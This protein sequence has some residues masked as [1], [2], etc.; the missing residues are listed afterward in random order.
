MSVSIKPLKGFS[1][2]INNESNTLSLLVKS[3][4]ELYEHLNESRNK[5]ISSLNSI[6]NYFKDSDIKFYHKVQIPLKFKNNTFITSR[7]YKLSFD[8]IKVTIDNSLK[9]V[10]ES[11]PNS[12]TSHFINIFVKKN[13]DTI[14]LNNDKFIEVNHIIRD[15]ISNNHIYNF[16]NNN[17]FEKIMTKIDKKNRYIDKQTKIINKKY[18]HILRQHMEYLTL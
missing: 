10:I 1:N 14:I 2:P 12:F 18:L 6:L 15:A 3:D 9:D 5:L 13:G 11:C 7:C 8:S 16:S 4:Y 17:P